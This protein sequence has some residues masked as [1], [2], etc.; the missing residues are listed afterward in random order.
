M[1]KSTYGNQLIKSLVCRTVHTVKFLPYARTP[2]PGLEIA[3][4]AKW[5]AK[6]KVRQAKITINCQMDNKMAGKI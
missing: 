4:Y 5:Q 3:A 6:F 1:I 2:L